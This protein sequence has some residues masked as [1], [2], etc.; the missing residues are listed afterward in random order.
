MITWLQIIKSELYLLAVTLFE[1]QNC[2]TFLE[3]VP[4]ISNFVLFM[5]V[6]THTPTY[7]YMHVQA[8]IVINDCIN[9]Q[10]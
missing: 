9:V 6:C 3:N 5:H 2:C 8:H 1:T 4:N 10:S 7:L